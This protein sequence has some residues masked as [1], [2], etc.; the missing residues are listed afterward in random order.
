MMDLRVLDSYATI[1]AKQT[2]KIHE[3]EKRY[4][5][6]T[7]DLK[8]ECLESMGTEKEQC[9]K[10]LDTLHKVCHNNLTEVQKSNGFMDEIKR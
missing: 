10:Q 4:I 2:K 1:N 5:A 3:M 7:K 9:Y 8:N 6:K